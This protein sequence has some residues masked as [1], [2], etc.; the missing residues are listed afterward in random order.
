M[1]TFCILVRGI[2]GSGKSTFGASLSEYLGVPKIEADDYFLD[3]EGRYCF[4][5][6]E[7]SSA[8]VDCQQRAVRAASNFGGVIVCNTFTTAAEMEFYF[9]NFDQVLVMKKPLRCYRNTH[10]VPAHIITQMIDRWEPM[11]GE[12]TV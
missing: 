1:K 3:E 10:E 2:P 8:H 5:K 7:L 6:E 9:N 12:L 4:Q 11:D